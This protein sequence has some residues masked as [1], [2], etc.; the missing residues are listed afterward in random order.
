MPQ[1][2]RDVTP[3]TPS[4]PCRLS[5][6]DRPSPPSRTPP[7]FHRHSNYDPRPQMP[8]LGH[9]RANSRSR[10]YGQGYGSHIPPTSYI[11]Q[12]LSKNHQRNN[13]SQYSPPFGTP[14]ISSPPPLPWPP[15]PTTVAP[16]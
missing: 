8:S 10:G 7:L 5:R 1:E 2:Q 15:N 3:L 11:W 6:P 14:Y 13:H 4:P 9:S 12:I 16:D